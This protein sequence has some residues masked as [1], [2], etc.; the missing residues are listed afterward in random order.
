LR[1]VLAEL[2][3]DIH[4]RPK[5]FLLVNHQNRS[6]ANS[7][8]AKY[9]SLCRH[10][11]VH[12]IKCPEDVQRRFKRERRILKDCIKVIRFLF[13]HNAAVSGHRRPRRFIHLMDHRQVV[14]D[15]ALDGRTG[16]PD[17]IQDKHRYV[18]LKGFAQAFVDLLTSFGKLVANRKQTPQQ[19]V[20]AAIPAR[21]GN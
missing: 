2:A 17:H 21:R 11:A 14:N 3:R 12:R 1:D 8:A 18:A 15:S 13:D 9:V 20:A 5:Y 4:L 19:A 7:D 16:K 6:V 10:Y